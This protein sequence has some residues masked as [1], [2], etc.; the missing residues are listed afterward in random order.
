M[1]PYIDVINSVRTFVLSQH[2][3]NEVMTLMKH[4]IDVQDKQIRL[5][6]NISR[7]IN[8]LKKGPFYSGKILL[9]DASKPYRTIEERKEIIKEAKSKFIESLGILEATEDKSYQHFLEIGFVKL[10]VG[11]TWLL[12]E[13]KYDALDWIENSLD[14]LRKSLQRAKLQEVKY[15]NQL[16]SHQKQLKLAEEEHNK[17]RKNTIKHIES[18]DTMGMFLGIFS[19][20]KGSSLDANVQKLKGNTE[21]IE[22]SYDEMIEI[23]SF[24]KQFREFLSKTHETISNGEF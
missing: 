16:S 17:N 24:L 18:D 20:I 1:I 10:Y 7:D 9:L 12:L 13:K 11:F 4:L 2:R 14:S 15:R 22:G 21:Y 23:V 5:I 19:Q 3:H 6:E 8:A